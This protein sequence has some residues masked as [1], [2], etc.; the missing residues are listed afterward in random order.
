MSQTTHGGLLQIISSGA[1]DS[2]LTSKPEI[3]F[4]KKVYKQ[5][6]NFSVELKKIYS[7]NPINFNDTVTFTLNN[8]DLIH[9]CYL[10]IEIPYLNFSDNII[11]NPSYNE[12]KN[13]MIS[14]YTKKKNDWKIKYDNLNNYCNLILQ[15]YKLLLNLLDASNVTITLLKNC[16]ERFNYINKNTIDNYTNNI[17]ISVLNK[18]NLIFYIT[19]Y[20]IIINNT[21]KINIINELKQMYDN[22]IYYLRYYNYHILKYDNL[23]TEKTKNNQI[24]FSF[25][26]YLGHIFFKS[27]S[28]EIGGILISEYENDFLHI[29]QLHYLNDNELDTYLQ[30]IGHRPELYTFNNNYKGNT[31]IIIPLMFWF[32][33]DIGNSLPL[34]SLQYAT[35]NIHVKLNNI[36]KII[37]FENYDDL[38]N[39]LLKITIDNL[40]NNVKINNKLIYNK[41]EINDFYI[42]YYCKYINAELLRLQFTNL[43]END[44]EFILQKYGSYD[45][46]ILLLNNNL[47]IENDIDNYYIN[48]FQWINFMKN[49]K[50]YT[51]IAYKLGLYYPYA[52]FD[53]YYSKINSF[54]ITLITENIFISDIERERYANNKLEYI[55]ETYQQNTYEFA[56]NN[57]FL[58]YELSFTKLCKELYWYIQP[59]LLFNGYNNNGKNTELIFDTLLLSN[60]L[61]VQFQQLLFDN[62]D[63]LLDKKIEMYDTHYYTYLL[64]YKYLN[65]IL[66]NGIYYNSFCLYP[67]ETQP[68]GAVN[69]RYIKSKNYIININQLFINDYNQILIDLNEEHKNKFKLT[70]ISKNYELLII[71]KGQCNFLFV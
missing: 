58:N 24:N 69:L 57:L 67:E 8:G 41:Y 64:S 52:D 43:H 32:N 26:E 40:P 2:V 29:N 13:I 39:N 21:N 47:I 42:I 36:Y 11:T 10:E 62:F 9:K 17:D 53:I 45:E 68:S 61:L 30:L 15:L 71:H 28:I 3:T 33:K 60:N 49:V 35:V 44:I 54:N 66:S 70:F 34:I 48:M 12:I 38:Y 50:N 37:T 4:F 65:N 7:N 25:A 5:Y 31:K 19:N 59:E 56:N 1:E 55:I 63:V 22:M 18:I 27:Y 16:V 6:S 20:N 14:N 23:I 51:L 46:N